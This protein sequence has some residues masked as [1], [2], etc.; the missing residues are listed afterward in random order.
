MSTD[1]RDLLE[2]QAAWQRAR[3]SKPWGEKLRESLA[4]KGTMLSLRK[5]TRP[6]STPDADSQQGHHD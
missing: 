6:Q 4:M 3:A 5:S 1:L 2:R